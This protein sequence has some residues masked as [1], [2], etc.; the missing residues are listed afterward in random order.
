VYTD[1]QVLKVEKTFKDKIILSGQCEVI[2]FLLTI[3]PHSGKI[4]IKRAEDDQI[5][6][7]WDK[8]CYYPRQHFNLATT[9]QGETV[10]HVLSDTFD[11]SSCK[12]K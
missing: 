11:T 10:M 5:K 8:S 3:G 9:V 4:L 2:G 7:T 1:L 12:K 6:N